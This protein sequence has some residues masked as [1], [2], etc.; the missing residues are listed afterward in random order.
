MDS[1]D[2]HNM[3]FKNNL[4]WNSNASQNVFVYDPC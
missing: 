1:P 4:E 2:L 3:P